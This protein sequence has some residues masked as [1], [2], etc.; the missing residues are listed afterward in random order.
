[1]FSGSRAK[2]AWFAL[3]LLGAF[4]LHAIELYQFDAFQF[5][6]V[7]HVAATVSWLNGRGFTIPDVSPAG[8]TRT[9]FR[10]LL[11][12]LPGYALALAPVMHITRDIWWSTYALDLAAQCV[13]LVS[14]VIL[15]RVFTR[16]LAA[17]AGLLLLWTVL[18]SPV[19]AGTYSDLLALA[20]FSAGRSE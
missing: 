16:S 7:N 14:W 8:L 20:I 6:K 1:M 9:V 10:P 17:A 12:F 19:A 13:F 18:Y 4:A 5:D 3:A 15:L 2:A 11:G